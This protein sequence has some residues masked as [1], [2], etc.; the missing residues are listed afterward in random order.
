[1]SAELTLDEVTRRW[2]RHVQ[3]RLDLSEASLVTYRRVGAHVQ[4]WGE[5]R[6]L[7][8]LDLAPYAQIRRNAGLAPRTLCLELRVI[9]VL[10]R[11]AVTTGLAPAAGTL[12]VPRVKVDPKRF[13]VN[14]S[15]PNPSDVARVLDEMAPDDFGLALLVIARTGAR[16]GEV[17]RLRGCDVD[18]RT[19]R[20]SF[21]Q[22]EGAS[23][24]GIRSFPLDA[25]TL[26][27]LA[28]RP[29]TGTAPL[30]D[31]GE[32]T[33]PIQALERRMARACDA[34]GVPR[35]TPHGL[36]R[37][38]VSRLMRAQVDP[39]TAATLTGHSVQVMLR[40]YQQVTEGDQRAAVARAPLGD[41]VD[42]A[43]G[44]GT[45]PR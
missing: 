32:I 38:V 36:R 17:L 4:A 29:R 33:C 45:A 5:G 43:D 25:S 18:R 23:K 44:G 41:L 31:F 3:G 20:V 6:S 26:A 10:F 1:M 28:P 34:A 37:M 11:W 14:H 40:H 16:V 12:R 42:S 19:G 39:G 22:V 35:F 9:G 15:T 13:V 30:F 24:S 7:V 27:E 8:G 2:L 21:G